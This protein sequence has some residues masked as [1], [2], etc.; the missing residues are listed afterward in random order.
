MVGKYGSL[1][2]TAAQNELKFT[3][4]CW[5]ET[6]RMTYAVGS[7]PRFATLPINTPVRCAELPGKCPFM[8]SVGR[9]LPPAASWRHRL[10]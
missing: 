3:L 7:V 8:V 2:S 5:K 9:L 10:P 6:A 4:A 1:A